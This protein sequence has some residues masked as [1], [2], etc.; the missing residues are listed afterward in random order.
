MI[1]SFICHFGAFCADCQQ[2]MGWKM[3]EAS[4]TDVSQVKVGWKINE[5]SFTAQNAEWQGFMCKNERWQMFCVKN[6]IVICHLLHCGR[7]RFGSW[8]MP[9]WRVKWRQFGVR[10][11]YPQT[12]S[13][14]AD[15]CV[16][17]VNSGEAKCMADLRVCHVKIQMV[18]C[19]ADTRCRSVKWD[20]SKWGRTHGLPL[21]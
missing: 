21:L 13:V 2:V 8:Y 19:R 16:C 5:A 6:V 11:V 1:L 14:G 17:P 3:H 9:F 15:P 10:L 12:V 18:K 20:A 7:R 4:F